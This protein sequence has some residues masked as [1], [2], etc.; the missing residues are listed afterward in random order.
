MVN[1]AKK[2]GNVFGFYEGPTPILVISDPDM[3]M[4]VLVKQF[5][6]FHARKVRLLT[7]FLNKKNTFDL[8]GE[9]VSV[10]GSSLNQQIN[11]S[12]NR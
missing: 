4:E 7:N 8:K 2:Y 1:W 10:S 3:V 6:N 5:S 12:I 9:K 11:L